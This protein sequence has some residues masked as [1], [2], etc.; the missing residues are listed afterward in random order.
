MKKSFLL[1]SL[2]VIIV[3]AQAQHEQDG[4]PY[5]TTAPIKAG[6][7]HTFGHIVSFCFVIK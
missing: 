7:T 1:L 3:T 6:T 4:V 2:I 5:L